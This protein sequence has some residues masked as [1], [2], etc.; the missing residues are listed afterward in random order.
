MI[1]T[2]E[3]KNYKSIDEL[4]LDLG[5][6]NVFIGENGCGKSNILEAI[7][8]AAASAANKLD[9][10]FLHNRGIRVTSPDRMRSGFEVSSASRM[11]EVALSDA[12]HAHFVARLDHE[13]TRFGGWIDRAA[14][15]YRI[16][17][18]PTLTSWRIVLSDDPNEDDAREWAL[19][20]QFQRAI[21]QTHLDGVAR[22]LQVD[23][24][25]IYTPHEEVLRDLARDSGIEPVGIHGEGLFGLIHWFDGLQVLHGAA[26]SLNAI[27]IVDQYLG[28][29]IAKF[30]Q[31]SANEGFLFLLLYACAARQLAHAKILRRRQR[32]RR[33]QPQAERRRDQHVRRGRKKHDRQVLL[34]DPQ[35]RHPRR[36]RPARS[37][38]QRLFVVYRNLDG[39]TRVRRIE[40]D[41]RRRT[42]SAALRGVPPAA[43][44]AASRTTS[45]SKADRSGMKARDLRASPSS[46]RAPP[47]ISS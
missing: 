1:R 33:A 5:R 23:K 37:D 11:I 26:P 39:R 44:W 9:N 32:R 7:G 15:R 29:G 13:G 4:T 8:L 28:D 36:P 17:P 31:R 19:L 41:P 20:D 35:P 30:D 2:I 10:E 25:L 27:N 6:V 34:D 40:R 45:R 47:T 12:R 42:L 38:E 46:P 18:G 16:R 24:F 21:V 22:A 14:E 3:I 43:T